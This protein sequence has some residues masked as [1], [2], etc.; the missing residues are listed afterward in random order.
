L[1][2]VKSDLAGSGGEAN[3]QENKLN[4]VEQLLK[5]AMMQTALEGKE[6]ADLGGETPKGKE[7]ETQSQQTA[8]GNK[9]LK[10]DNITIDREIFMALVQA[11][12]ELKSPPST[13]QESSEDEELVEDMEE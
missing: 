3:P 5:S 1:E 8:A 12:K 13:K 9:R 6:T 11:V 4:L 7:E 10:T 2:Q